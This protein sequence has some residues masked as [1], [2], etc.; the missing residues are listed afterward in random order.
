LQ[1]KAQIEALAAAVEEH[2]A[3]AEAKK[4]QLDE[5]QQADDVARKLGGSLAEVAKLGNC[6]RGEKVVVVAKGKYSVAG[7]TFADIVR[8]CTA[9]GDGSMKLAWLRSEHEQ[10]DPA[11][12]N[13]PRGSIKRW[14]LDDADTMKKVGK[15]GIAGQPHWKVEHEAR[16][17]TSLDRAGGYLGSGEPMLGKAEEGMMVWM[18]DQAKRGTP[19][20]RLDAEGILREAAMTLGCRIPTTGQLYTTNTDVRKMTDAFLVRCTERGVPFVEKKGQGL[21]LQRAAAASVATVQEFMTM[22]SG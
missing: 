20:T 19:T 9:L 1:K 11:T 8:L 10:H 6:K 2:T 17:R 7:H 15:T 5:I 18:G 22:V 13:V 3:A 14:L 16:R 4:K 12:M 21:S